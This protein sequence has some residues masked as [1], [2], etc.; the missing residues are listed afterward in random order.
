MERDLPQICRDHSEK[1]DK[2][3]TEPLPEMTISIR[4]FA[5]RSCGQQEQEYTS[6]GGQAFQ[7]LLAPPCLN[8]QHTLMEEIPTEVLLVHCWI[9]WYH[10]A[11]EPTKERL[12]SLPMEQRKVHKK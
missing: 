5:L 10:F 1:D 12:H 6:Q 7:E 8:R 9:I 2:M 3:T 11:F 4:L